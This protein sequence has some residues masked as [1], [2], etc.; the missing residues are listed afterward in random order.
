[1]ENKYYTPSIEEFHVGFECETFDQDKALEQFDKK[2]EHKMFY[3]INATFKEDPCFKP[4]IIDGNDI[5][6]YWE[7]THLIPMYFRVKYLTK[8]DIESLGFIKD[9]NVDEI[10]R[11]YMFSESKNGGE[12]NLELFYYYDKNRLKITNWSGSY[13]WD[14][15]D[16]II[17]NKSELKTLLKQLGIDVQN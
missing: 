6:R 5:W 4:H 14:L 13:N 9:T 11:Y 7:N 3:G 8:E 15:F 2:W 12:L 1:M 17:K 16:G 10:F